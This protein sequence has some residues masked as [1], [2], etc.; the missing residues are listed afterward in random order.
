VTDEVQTSEPQRGIVD[1]FH[2][3]YYDAA[4][5]GGTWQKTAWLGVPTEK[6]PLD[7]WIYQ[8]ILHEMRPDVIVETGTRWGG[9]ALFL[10]SMCDLLGKGRVITID[11][12]VPGDRP[13]HER[14]TYLLGSSTSP[15]ILDDVHQRAKGAERVMVVL[16]S[17]HSMNHVLSELRSYA[18]VVTVGSYIVV[19]DTN[20]NGNPVLPDFG[21]GPMEAV[22]RFLEENQ[23]FEPDRSR[24]KFLLTFNPNGFLRRIE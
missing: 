17:D 3:L 24:E 7:L 8:E 20:V 4:G 5:T 16:D 10:A 12:D 23:A 18:D 13:H 22:G 14:I 19:E 15:A 1:A 11:I 21:A 6:C 2:R 9:S